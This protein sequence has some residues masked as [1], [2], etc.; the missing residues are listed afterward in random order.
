MT[1][2]FLCW[3]WGVY[4]PDPGPC[5]LNDNVPCGC[6]P[7]LQQTL[8]VVGEVKKKK[9]HKY[10][11]KHSRNKFTTSTQIFCFSPELRQPSHSKI[12]ISWKLILAFTIPNEPDKQF[13]KEFMCCCIRL[14]FKSEIPFTAFWESLGNFTSPLSEYWWTLCEQTKKLC[15]PF[16]RNSHYFAPPIRAV[17]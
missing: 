3:L 9:I 4:R 8:K 15:H 6:K 5:Q 1:S 10:F 7:V 12:I 11:A 16:C 13:P 17:K 14:C 2:F